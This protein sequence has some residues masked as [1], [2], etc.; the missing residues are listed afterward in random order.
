V[1]NM[2]DPLTQTEPNGE[3]PDQS[4]ED[5]NSRPDF[6]DYVSGPLSVKAGCGFLALVLFL[7][8]LLFTGRRFL[9][10]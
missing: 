8:L 6:G 4:G 7:I 2:A 5:Q 9:L 3:N 10:R 1:L